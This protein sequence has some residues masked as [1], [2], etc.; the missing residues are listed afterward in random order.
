MV[1]RAN[2]I[3]FIYSWIPSGARNVV[4]KAFFFPTPNVPPNTPFHTHSMAIN[5]SLVSQKAVTTCYFIAPHFLLVLCRQLLT[6]SLVSISCYYLTLPLHIIVTFPT[7]CL[8]ALCTT[9]KSLFGHTV[10][11]LSAHAQDCA[12]RV[13]SPCVWQVSKSAATPR[14][15]AQEKLHQSWKIIWTRPGEVHGTCLSEENCFLT[16]TALLSAMHWS[17]PYTSIYLSWASFSCQASLGPCTHIMPVQHSPSLHNTHTSTVQLISWTAKVLA[18]FSLCFTDII[19]L[20]HCSPFSLSR[21]TTS[22]SLPSRT[23]TAYIHTTVSQLLTPTSDQPT[24]PIFILLV[25]FSQKHPHA[26]SQATPYVLTGSLADL[27]VGA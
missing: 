24:S 1:I 27:Y 15:S 8:N 22:T 17:N 7:M 20:D 16:C 6:T 3:S 25:K 19:S 2:L 5:C 10:H 4:G 12:W 14:S 18:T 23:F 21:N 9:Q 13:S 11:K 26:F